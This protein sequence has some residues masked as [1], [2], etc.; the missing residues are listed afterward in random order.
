MLGSRHA[1]PFR[2]RRGGDGAS[3]AVLP[4]LEKTKDGHRIVHPLDQPGTVPNGHHGVVPGLEQT[5]C[6]APRAAQHVVHD[7]EQLHDTRVEAQVVAALEE[8]PVPPPVGA[9][10]AQF[11]G[12]CFRRQHGH[13]LL[14]I[15]NGDHAAPA[16]GARPSCAP[17]TS[18]GVENAASKSRDDHPAP[19]AVARPP[20]K[21]GANVGHFQQ[22]IVRQQL[23]QPSLDGA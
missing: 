23:A 4:L 12:L 1:L 8:E 13:F 19:A 6:C 16:P 9:D 20:R 21:K 3:L 17:L 15:G 7:G 22:R 18:R 11:L 2:S 14:K 5:G 10:D